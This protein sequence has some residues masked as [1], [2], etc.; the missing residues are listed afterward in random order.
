MTN[1]EKLIDDI[2][3]LFI[4]AYIKE[5][6]NDETGITKDNVAKYMHEK[7]ICSRPTTLR[8]IEALLAEKILLDKRTRKNVF[9]DLVV[10]EEIPFD[11]LLK[12]SL[13][14]HIEDVEQALKPFEILTKHKIKVEKDKDE[15]R[16]TISY[17]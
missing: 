5:N 4:L 14:K 9:H 12:K 6:E 13:K 17:R 16:A 7:G 3:A 11:D 8:I 15:T 1:N 10:S 2:K